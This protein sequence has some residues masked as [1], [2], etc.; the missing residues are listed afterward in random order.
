VVEMLM[1]AQ[2]KLFDSLAEMLAQQ[3]LSELL[4]RPVSSVEI[5]PMTDHS[6][7]AGSKLSYV[8]TDAGIYVLKRMSP[9]FDYL[10]LAT[11]DQRCRSV[12]LWQYGL[13]DEL[14]PHIDH[15]IIA[16]AQDGDGW[17]ILMQ[18]L[19]E[20]LFSGDRPITPSQ[21]TVF[22]DRL[23][24]LHARFWND[25]R[26]G[27]PQIGLNDITARLK[28]TSPRLAQKQNGDQRG[29]LPRAIRQG[30][31]I[32]EYLIEPD[33]FQILSSLSEN[34]EPLAAALER[35]PYTLIH[36][37]YRNANLAHLEPDQAVVFDWHL[38]S[39]TLMT[40]DLAF[41]M[42]G[43]V[44]RKSIEQIDAIRYY[45]EKLET[46]L[47]FTFNDETWQAMLDLGHL[48]D[49]VYKA[50]FHAYLSKHHQKPELRLR[51]EMMMKEHIQNTRKGIRW[52]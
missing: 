47:G 40:V 36:G 49:A 33:I 3:T 14:R 44:V 12:R 16:C 27:D 50:A 51:F 24:R 42:G 52:L 45:Q 4:S 25:P 28:V 39:R 5:Q 30:W 31:E 7:L 22:L 6:G 18:D 43:P 11:N 26:L 8:Q 1:E 35:Y 15:K 32:L 34:P 21:V 20:G 19:S 48:T 29:P 41:F 13:L 17:G 23:A 46:Y 37:D 2:H 10:I 9:E 38:A